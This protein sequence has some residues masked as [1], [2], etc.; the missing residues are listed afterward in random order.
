MFLDRPSNWCDPGDRLFI[1]VLLYVFEYLKEDVSTSCCQGVWRNGRK[2]RVRAPKFQCFLKFYFAPIS[3][4]V[5]SL[6]KN[7][8]TPVRFKK[9]LLFNL[10][11]VELQLRLNSLIQRP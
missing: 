5:E 1:R 3:S 9:A 11:N 8:L 2:S 4:D 6:S 10:K 7:S